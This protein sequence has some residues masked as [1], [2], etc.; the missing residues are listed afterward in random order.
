MKGISRKRV[1]AVVMSMVSSVSIF[2]SVLPCESREVKAATHRKAISVGAGV[3]G[4]DFNTSKAATVYF[5]A[6]GKSPI[7]WRVVGND[8][9]GIGMNYNR[10]SLTLLSN[11][12][13][14]S[15]IS[16]DKNGLKNEYSGS[17][18]H[19]QV[20]EMAEN[21]FS[22]A[23]KSAFATRLLPKG[24]YVSEEPYTDGVAGS[25]LTTA[26]LWPLSS[27]EAFTL[28]PSI[29]KTEGEY[30]LRSPGYKS[31]FS[32]YVNTNGALSY[33]GIDS[34]MKK[35]VRPAFNLRMNSVVLTSP[36]KNGKPSASSNV[37][38]LS[39]IKD[40][41]GSQWKLTILDRERSGFNAYLREQTVYAGQTCHIAYSDA[42]LKTTDKD[43]CVSVVLLDSTATPL[44]YGCIAYRS[45]SGTAEM[46][47]PSGLSSGKYKMLVFSEIRNGDYYTDFASNV[48]EFSIVI[49]NTLTPVCAAPCNL[50]TTSVSNSYVKL[51]WDA[52]EGAT[53]YAVYRSI[54]ASGPFTRVGLVSSTERT[55]PGLTSGVKY[56]F[57]VRAYVEYD[58][59]IHL[60][61]F[62]SVIS[63]VPRLKAPENVSS[64]KVNANT[65]KVKW[66]SVS[67]AAGY[68]VYRSTSE[69]GTYTRLGTVSQTNRNCTS[70]VS[71]RTYY[72]KVRAYVVIDGTT[73]YGSYSTPVR[74]VAG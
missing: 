4:F 42:V 8:Q 1:L 74:Y 6:D 29:R 56:Y 47:I 49:D 60:G 26:R 33:I 59:E 54:S 20:Y 2:L 44:Y 27:N 43:E 37:G 10:G 11:K 65:A 62:S 67:G 58:G 13:L 17:T 12:V 57:K 72:F 55:C 38:T 19:D 23:E 36:A 68:V 73:Y 25:E 61:K 48:V 9:H 53:G 21:D 45:K 41:T 52:V 24:D 71:G 7:A 70:L 3:L 16:F 22:D 69:N 34:V 39:L 40:C 15:D 31:S 64:S 51:A 46:T 28:D 35:G 50:K 14:K 66:S 30:W 5:G 18:L 63:A 32:A